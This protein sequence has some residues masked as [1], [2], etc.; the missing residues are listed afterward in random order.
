MS[1]HI[2]SLVCAWLQGTSDFNAQMCVIKFGKGDENLKPVYITNCCPKY[3][4]AS[5]L[6]FLIIKS[7]HWPY[8][9]TKTGYQKSV[10]SY[11]FQRCTSDFSKNCTHSPYSK[12][13][14][15]SSLRKELQWIL[16]EILK[17]K[18]ASNRTSQLWNFVKTTGP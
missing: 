2:R 7:K 8:Y 12:K 14:M 15:F 13:K 10:F 4:M 18:N 11:W 5:I 3:W 6:D 17:V 1:L 16:F 9:E